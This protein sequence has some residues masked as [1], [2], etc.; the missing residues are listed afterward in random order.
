MLRRPIF[1]YL[2]SALKVGLCA[3]LGVW[4]VRYTPA[5]LRI[6][7]WWL[8]FGHPKKHGYLFGW[9]GWAAHR[10]PAQV[11]AAWHTAWSPAPHLPI[12]LLQLPFA[13]VAVWIL[14]WRRRAQTLRAATVATHGSARWRRPAELGRTLQQVDT[15]QP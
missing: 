2:R 15:E 14:F 13:C 12:L 11:L 3:M 8:P 10:T 1:W 4:D 9:A 6:S 5:A 7:A